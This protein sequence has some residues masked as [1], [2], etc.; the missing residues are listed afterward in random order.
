MGVGRRETGFLSSLPFEGAGAVG[1]PHVRIEIFERGIV[2]ISCE[3]S[4]REGEENRGGNEGRGTFGQGGEFKRYNDSCRT[5]DERNEA[6]TKPRCLQTWL[7]NGTAQ[8]E[9]S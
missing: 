8:P 1:R 9:D 7:W 3:I 4:M 5:A 6:W 2:E